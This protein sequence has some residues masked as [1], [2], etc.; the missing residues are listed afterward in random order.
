[1]KTK[2]LILYGGSSI[3]REV[4]LM[5]A[6]KI[7]SNIDYDKYE[8]SKIEVPHNKKNTEWV[9]NIIKINP[10]IV[11]I[12]LHGGDGENAANSQG[13]AQAEA[14]VQQAVGRQEG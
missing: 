11:F 13:A 14:A 3:E 9:T 6:E 4:S 5:T 1:M 10:D 2:V 7:L 12:A 8:V